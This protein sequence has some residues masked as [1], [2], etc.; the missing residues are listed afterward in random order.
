MVRKSSAINHDNHH[1]IINNT[2]D[3]S[4]LVQLLVKDSVFEKHLGQKCEAETSDLFL[5]GIAKMATGI[6]LHK[7]QMRTR[8]N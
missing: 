8:E 5:F 6:P 4:K 3:V 1:S 2:I 7:Y